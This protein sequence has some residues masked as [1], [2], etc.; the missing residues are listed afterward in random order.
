MSTW[1]GFY[2][3]SPGAYIAVCEYLGSQ[4]TQ[5]EKWEQNEEW[6]SGHSRLGQAWVS[7]SQSKERKIWRKWIRDTKLA[8]SLEI[9][10]FSCYLRRGGGGRSGRVKKIRKVQHQSLL[11][12]AS[13]HYS[14]S[15]HV[16]PM[17]PF[18][19]VAVTGMIL[20]DPI[21]VKFVRL[22]LFVSSSSL[23]ITYFAY[24]YSSS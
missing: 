15:C 16:A 4:M 17:I 19:A 20:Q 3:D 12:A 6:Q 2:L 9:W 24:R 14:C 22:W 13:L 10:C 21:V 8:G 23:E 5:N 7:A 11:G 1:C 18:L